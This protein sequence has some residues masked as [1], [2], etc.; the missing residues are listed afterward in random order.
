MEIGLAARKDTS[1]PDF[2]DRSGGPEAPPIISL[3]E[4]Q[5]LDHCPLRASSGSDFKALQAA[6][7]L[8]EVEATNLSAARRT[9]EAATRAAAGAHRRGERVKK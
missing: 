1:K 9:P 4:E 8:P 5:T 7:T 3:R 6:P 2:I